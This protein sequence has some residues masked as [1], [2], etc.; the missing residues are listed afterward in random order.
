MV[1]VMPCTANKADPL[2]GASTGAAPNFGRTGGVAEAALRSAAVPITGS[3]LGK[4]KFEEL[5]TLEG[6]KTAV[7]EL[8]GTKLRVAVARGL[9]RRLGSVVEREPVAT[10]P[11]S[12][13]P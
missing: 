5:G 4:L 12:H 1:S 7:V 6:I 11:R 10:I 9:S 2:L 13:L 8:S 3:P